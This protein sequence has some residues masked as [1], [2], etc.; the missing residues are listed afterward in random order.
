MAP[1]K[2]STSNP[3]PPASQAD[4]SK[5]EA[6]ETKTTLDKTSRSKWS[7]KDMK[8]Y[9]KALE[10]LAAPDFPETRKVVNP[11]VTAGKSFKTLK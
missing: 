7:K 3:S 4:I 6:L 1:N 9:I 10:V 5:L 8:T 11:E 2:K